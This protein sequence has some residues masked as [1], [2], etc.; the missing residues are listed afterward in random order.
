[1]FCL[2][3]APLPSLLSSTPPRLIWSSSSCPTLLSP[4]VSPWSMR[5]HRIL[6]LHP[7]LHLH[8][9]H[10]HHLHGRDSRSLPGRPIHVPMLSPS[11]CHS[12][13]LRSVQS[14]PSV[15]ALA[16]TDPVGLP[17]RFGMAVGLSYCPDPS[18]PMATAAASAAPSYSGAMVVWSPCLVPSL[19]TSWSLGL[20]SFLA[21]LALSAWIVPSVAAASG[22]GWQPQHGT[23][24]EPGCMIYPRPCPPSFPA[25]RARGSSWAAG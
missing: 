7:H 14:P 1:M 22:T 9:H 25:E 23:N 20:F 6:H 13:Q 11:S 12:S 10:H 17:S 18:P 16:R 2:D 5:P 24:D 19:S 21:P 4:P 8:L 3:V 15:L